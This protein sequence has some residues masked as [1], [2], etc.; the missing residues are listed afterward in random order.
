MN[1]EILQFG[2]RPG[3][4]TERICAYAIVLNDQKQL[5][6][7][8]VRDVY[9]LPGGGVE[10]GEDSQAAAIRETMEEAG[11]EITDL[12][13]L[14]KANQYCL[15]PQLKNLNKL[16]TFYIARMIRFDFSKSIEADHTPYWLPVEEFLYGPA[17]EFHKWAVQEAIKT[18]SA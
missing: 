7:L 13:F 5:L 3:E 1:K 16:A 11:C 8:K 10:T 18:I 14:G 9:H 4:F 17:R 12:E 2:E 15:K 6:V